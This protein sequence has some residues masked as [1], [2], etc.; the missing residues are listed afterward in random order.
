MTISELYRNL[1]SELEEN[2]HEVIGDNDSAHD[3]VSEIIEGLLPIY[4]ADALEV[5]LSDL[6]LAV[7]SPDYGDNPY[8]MLLANIDSA[9]RDRASDWIS[10]ARNKKGIFETPDKTI[11]RL[12]NAIN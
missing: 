12:K 8:E 2:R 6:A 11:K 1:E 9:L 10:R 5:A 7:E 4:T 3:R